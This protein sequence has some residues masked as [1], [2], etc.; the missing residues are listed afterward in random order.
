M[1]KP[2]RPKQPKNFSP[3][4]EV[5]TY[6]DD[7]IGYQA[8]T[9]RAHMKK[10]VKDGDILGAAKAQIVAEYLE[11]TLEDGQGITFDEHVAILD[12]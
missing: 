11:G 3:N 7:V 12:D 4:D 8:E 1:A 10:L 6:L 9:M 2:K 5:K